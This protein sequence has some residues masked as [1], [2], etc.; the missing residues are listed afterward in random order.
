MADFNDR[1][2]SMETDTSRMPNNPSTSYHVVT[3][4]LRSGSQASS[5][6]VT[7]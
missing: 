3:G 2:K 6:T 4:F 1:K 5:E 7:S